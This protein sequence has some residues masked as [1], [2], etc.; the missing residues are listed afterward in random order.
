MNINTSPRPAARPAALALAFAALLLLTAAAQTAP[1]PETYYHPHH[2][3]LPQTPPPR[4]DEKLPPAR[5]R[6]GADAQPFRIRIDDKEYNF[7]QLLRL[8]P[9]NTDGKN[10][11]ILTPFRFTHPGLRSDKREL[12]HIKQKL[13][14]NEEPWTT[15]YTH[16]KKT[17]PVE[18]IA[19]YFERLKPPPEII[20][21][22]FSGRGQ[23]GAF[24]EKRH[25]NTAYAHAL[26]YYLTGDERHATAAARIL[27]IYA[28]TVK[29]HEGGNWYLEVAWAGAIFPCAAEILKTAYPAWKDEK[30]VANWFNDV[31]LPPLH[32]RAA[33]GNRESAAL[34]AL[35]AIGVFNEDLAAIYEGLHRWMNFVP[36]YH[37]L[38]EE[39]GPAPRLPLYWVPG[40]H[41]SDEFLQKLN[42]ATPSATPA[43]R[44]P[45]TQIALK[46]WSMKDRRGKHGDDITHLRSCVFEKKDA[47]W[48]PAAIHSGYTTETTRDLAHVDVGFASEINAA[49]IAWHQGIDVYT[50]MQKRLTVFMETHLGLRLGHPPP[51]PRL[52]RRLGSDEKTPCRPKTRP[53]R[54]N[55]PHPLRH[56]L[57]MGNRLQ[58]LRQPQRPR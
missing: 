10:I 55:P 3:N 15:W 45:W 17:A 35:L 41:P 1:K 56:R 38:A 20:I 52:Q 23:V 31:F 37:Y 16:L 42:A 44:T 28:T 26:Q 11:K 29:S 14:A 36:A 25:A 18:R 9:A 51:P 7:A 57:D 22:G 50:P 19:E 49:E 47:G 21:S 6:D 54:K 48:I 24:D 58:P 13:A 33:A 4:P 30:L 46:K 5:L 27:N 40:I 32:N 43:T 2:G 8:H 53:Q 12:D 39:D 34:N